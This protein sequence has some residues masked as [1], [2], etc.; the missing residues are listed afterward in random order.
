MKSYEALKKELFKKFKSE[1]TFKE[2][3]VHFKANAHAPIPG[4]DVLVI[5]FL[6]RVVRE[7]L[8]TLHKM[9]VDGKIYNFYEPVTVKPLVEYEPL[10]EAPEALTVFSSPVIIDDKEWLT[11]FKAELDDL[12]ERNDKSEQLVETLRQQLL[13]AELEQ[14]GIMEAKAGLRKLVDNTAVKSEE[15]KPPKTI[16]IA[17]WC[18]KISGRLLTIGRVAYKNVWPYVHN[19]VAIEIAKK[20]KDYLLKGQYSKWSQEDIMS[21]AVPSLK[22]V[23]DNMRKSYPEYQYTDLYHKV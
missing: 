6:R 13:E 10:Y 23:E 12:I 22:I 11:K 4:S 14:L 20:D 15:E 8:L 7:G 5:N 2:A 21:I 1:F 16:D 17:K 18:N 9:D 3:R 19:L